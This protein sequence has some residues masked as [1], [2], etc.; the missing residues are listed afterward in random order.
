MLEILACLKIMVSL[1]VKF[2]CFFM[3]S[4]LFFKE[5]LPQLLA[6]G[7]LAEHASLFP[8]THRQAGGPSAPF[9]ASYLQQ[10]TQEE[11]KQVKEAFKVDMQL[12]GFT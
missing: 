4:L 5:E 2:T 11:V 8:H 9:T 1:T 10:L 3:P 6:V 12:F 7:G